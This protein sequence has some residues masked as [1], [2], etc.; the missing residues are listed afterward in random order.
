MLYLFWLCQ[1]ISE[2]G[3]LFTAV[4]YHY[5]ESDSN[6]SSPHLKHMVYTGVGLVTL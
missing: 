4:G 1:K 6:K 2:Q 5:N 3:R